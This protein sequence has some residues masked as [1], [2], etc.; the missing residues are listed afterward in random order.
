MHRRPPLKIKGDLTVTKG[1]DKVEIKLPDHGF[2]DEIHV[3]FVDTEPVPCDPHHHHHHHPHH[4]DEVEWHIRRVDG[5]IFLII[6]W[7]V[8]SPTRLI[9]WSAHYGTE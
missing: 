8:F 3:S 5:G 6:S 9:G 1:H 2:P 4:H 7:R